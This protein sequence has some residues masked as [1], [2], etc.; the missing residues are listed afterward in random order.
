MVEILFIK[1]TASNIPEGISDRE[2][3]NQNLY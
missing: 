2:R 1:R 3:M